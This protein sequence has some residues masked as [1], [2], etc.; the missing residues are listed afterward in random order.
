MSKFNKYARE[1]DSYIKEIFREYIEIENKYE[2]AKNKFNNTKKP[3]YVSD[4]S[5]I[6]KYARIKADYEE[7]KADYEKM[8]R[9]M[10][11]KGEKLKA[12]KSELEKSIAE[13]FAVKPEQLDNATLELL[14]SEI[15]TASE[16]DRLID[17]A[18]REDNATMVK[19]ISKYAKERADKE[20]ANRNTESARI[21]RV[22][23]YKGNSTSGKEYL[24]SFDTMTDCFNR[25]MRNPSLF[26][27][28][29][30]L[31][32]GIVERF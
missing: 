9:E 18:I 26:K 4:A 32:G 20:E 5:E 30:N 14:K 8:R 15:M 13:S 25:C 11:S 31:M 24:D 12:I 21:F 28:W 16:Y 3:A 22:V 2:T 27:E 7:A 10:F 29:D 19:L 23:A 1:V 6:A 17:R